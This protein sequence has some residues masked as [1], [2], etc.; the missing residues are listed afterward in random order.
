MGL[1][2]LMVWG[3]VAGAVA[4]VHWPV[5][6]TQALSFDDRTYLFE[7]PLILNPSWASVQRALSEISDSKT[8]EGYY[9]PLTLVSL[10][11]DV[12]AG[13]HV[14][15][16]L[17][18]HRTSLA[19]HV[20]NTLLIIVLIQFLFH[21]PLVAAA[22]GLLFGVH[23]MTVEPVAW[24][25]ERKTL[26][27][28]LLLLLS[29]I[30][31]V[32]HARSP[33][34]IVF[35]GA[36][37]AFGLSLLAKPIGMPMPVLLLL[38][39][40]WP[41][42]RWTRW[43]LAEKLPF[44]VLAI[45]SGVITVVSTGRTATVVLPGGA[46]VLS[47]PLKSCYLVLFYL[48]KI[49]WPVQ[50]TSCYPPPP[51]AELSE[52]LILTSLGG[53]LALAT[54]LMFSLRWTR[55]ATM[56]FLF[57][58]IGL[59]PT[60][61]VVGYSWV[62]ASDKYTYF[63]A[64]GLLI[65]LAAAA[66]TLLVQSRPAVLRLALGGAVVM[67]AAVLAVLTRQQ[68]GRWR[69]T[70]TL[71]RHMLTITPEVAQLHDCL[72]DE[73]LEQ[74]RF[75]EAIGHYRRAVALEPRW[76]KVRGDLGAALLAIQSLDEAEVELSEAIRLDP[77]LAK[78][79][80]NLAGVK[81]QRGNLGSAIDHYRRA[82]ELKPDLAQAHIGIGQA[83]SARGQAAD[84]MGHYQTAVRL[85]PNDAG[86]RLALALYLHA[87]GDAA[88]AETE[89]RRVLQLAPAE[90]RAHRG[91]GML[92]LNSARPKDAVSRLA[93]AVRIQP[94]NP[95]FSLEFARALEESGDLVRAVT[96]YRRTLELQPDLIPA[97]NDLA[98]ILATA[99][100]SGIRD[101]R[102]ALQLAL[103]AAEL[104]R[105]SDPAVLDTLAAAYAEVGDFAQAISLVRRAL[106]L[107]AQKPELATALRRH[108]NLYEGGRP[109]RS[110]LR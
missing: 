80:A 5:L 32:W 22:C 14:G 34:G 31:Y 44:L 35:L 109:C 17:P 16:L 49:I 54:S 10:M 63:P 39:D 41:L 83:L 103:R 87:R 62:T 90:A 65:L 96:Q 102:E 66:G 33:K 1:R 59:A 89:Y 47:L 69:D 82:I 73:L 79:Y 6:A 52:P 3:F 20:L 23:P 13:G 76:A 64:L 88:A 7:N 4:L 60:F 12:A 21:R 78:A 26:L 108:L 92:F 77:A 36:V 68:I 98:W 72:A 46:S 84:A 71:F 18:F 8:V 9:E 57:F 19:L 37:L 110:T 67:A 30:L 27:A 105:Q 38:L 29:L 53:I 91:L 51:P 2:A 107:A 50:L 56:G 45:L 42:R 11:L 61:G 104:T 24:V 43:R 93:D 70:E 100:D 85:R 95:E 25:W 15:H 75:A 101:G 99:N 74:R 48:G 81:M 97:L 40:W 86:V 106:H 58:V 28:T 94:T 55:A